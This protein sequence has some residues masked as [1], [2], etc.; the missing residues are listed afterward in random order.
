MKSGGN[1]VHEIVNAL[2]PSGE[3]DTHKTAT[4]R[5]LSCG[6]DVQKIVKIRTLS[7]ESDVQKIVT[8][9]TLSSESDVHGAQMHS[10]PMTA[11][12]TTHH[13]DQGG[14]GSRIMKTRNAG[15]NVQPLSLRG[16]G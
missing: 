6:S 15:L 10:V 2:M 12:S 9:R 11:Q 8:I 3:N 13:R 16:R 1:N 7:G 14:R 5:M 4:I